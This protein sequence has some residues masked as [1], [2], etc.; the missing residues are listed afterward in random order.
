MKPR[1]LADEPAAAFD[2]DNV[3]INH[4]AS[5]SLQTIL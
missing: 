3:T 2:L 5:L 4:T 1:V